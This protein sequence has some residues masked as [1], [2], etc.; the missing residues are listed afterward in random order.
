M[1]YIYTHENGGTIERKGWV[2]SAFRLY[3]D[4]RWVLLE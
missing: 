1:V 4:F 2:E 3:M